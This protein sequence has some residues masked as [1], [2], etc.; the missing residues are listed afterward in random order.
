MKKVCIAIGYKSDYSRI[1]SVV[2]AIRD[3]P[4]L[5]PYLVVASV[6][7]IP[8]YDDF[9][10]T[11]EEDGYKVD[12]LANTVIGT[13]N[14]A[15]MGQ[16]VAL[17][18]LQY[19]ILFKTIDPDVL[20]VIGDRFET[21][22]PVIAASFGNIPVVHIMG[23]EKSGTV[24]ES[25]RHAVS[26]FANLHFVANEDA[27]ERLIRM[28]EN[29]ETVYVTGCPS[30]DELLEIK[31]AIEAIDVREKTSKYI[32]VIQHP[33]TT[34]AGR[35]KSQMIETLEAIRQ[36]EHPVY[37][38]YPNID[39]GSGL[40]V[41]AIDEFMKSLSL[42]GRTRIR[43]FTHMPME[44]FIHLLRGCSCLVGNSSSGIRESCYFG[45]PTLNLGTRQN[46]RLR[47]K[48]VLDVPH[49]REEIKR[50]IENSLTLPRC[51]FKPEYLYGDGKAGEKI[52]EILARVEF[53]TTQK[54]LTY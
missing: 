42:K 5:E 48:N 36:I 31:R 35:A 19:P 39:G 21:L 53:K 27:K 24:D 34:E 47:G 32:M 11:I 6:S 17:G 38:W 8:W 46:G 49:D 13:R 1:K 25:V 20:V 15:A 23:G 33:V 9:L 50:W 40:M 37:L 41:E 51:R 29:P 28:G 18:L 54:T 14:I 7:G 3:H 10:K 4:D 44:R 16:S 26:K 30:V 12:Y 2:A 22:S 43:L 52:A 45:T